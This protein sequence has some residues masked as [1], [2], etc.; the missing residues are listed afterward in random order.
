MKDANDSEDDE[1]AQT[2]RHLAAPASNSA[3]PQKFFRGM[4]EHLAELSRLA[5]EHVCRL[6]STLPEDSGQRSDI[7]YIHGLADI[8]EAINEALSGATREILTAQPDGSRPSGVLKDALESVRRHI[9]AGVAMRTLYQH[10]TR[11]DEATKEYVREVTRLG[12][13]VRT[14]DEF[15]DR[16]V[17]V[18]DVAFIAANEDRT[19]AAA[20]RE[21]A[22]VRFLRDTFDRSWDRAQ[23]FPFV[24]HH[25]AK[26]A[27]EVIPAIRTSIKRLLIEGYPD[28]QIARRLGI[29]ERSLQTHIASMKQ[30]LGARNRLQMGYLLGRNGTTFVL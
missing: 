18:D 9:S 20:V 5:D 25:A 19:S 26:A 17:I 27:D 7:R 28:K 1:N 30:E 16:L 29:S 10:S 23:P 21:P 11:F 4:V 22:V 24:P 8:S 12:A 15:F 3:E 2:N 14:L 6:N 13:S